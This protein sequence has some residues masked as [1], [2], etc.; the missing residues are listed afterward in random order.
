MSG[1]TTVV[2]V[3]LVIAGVLSRRFGDVLLASTGAFIIGLFVL[4]ALFYVVTE[5]FT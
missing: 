4:S 3:L 2:V 1:A 5:V